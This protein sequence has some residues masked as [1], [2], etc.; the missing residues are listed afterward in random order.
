MKIAV[1]GCGNMASALVEGFFS[2][3]KDFDFYFYTPSLTRAKTLAEKVGGAHIEKLEDFKDLNIDYW[4]LGMKPQSVSEFAASF[5]KL[6]IKSPKIFSMLAAIKIDKLKTLFKTDFVTR[7]MPNTPVKFS[8][9]V[10]LV[11]HSDEASQKQREFS[12]TFLTA[13]SKVF[14][15]NELKLEL[16]TVLSGSGPAYF[17]LFTKL[18]SDALTKLGIDEKTSIELACE[19]LHGSSTLVQNETSKTLQEMIDNVTSK[20]GVTIEAV[21][22]FKDDDLFTLCERALKKA[23]QRGE[24]LSEELQ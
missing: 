14:E 16:A 20:G 7:I 15:M 8:Q 4:L 10:T 1:I 17:F 12:N 18:L 3:H 21:N 6:S 23:Y 11:S 5:N 19:T 22:S 13:T 9:G 24:K 2:H